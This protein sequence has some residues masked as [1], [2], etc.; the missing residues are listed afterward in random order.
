MAGLKAW[1]CQFINSVIL[2]FYGHKL[3]SL[4]PAFVSGKRQPLHLTRVFTGLFNFFNYLRYGTVFDDQR[5][6]RNERCDFG[7][8]E[9]GEHAPYIAVDG[10][11]PNLLT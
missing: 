10:F 9:F 2:P 8:P 6:R 3:R 7:I 11:I 1:L 5:T 4:Q